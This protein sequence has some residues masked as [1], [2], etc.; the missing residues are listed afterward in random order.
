MTIDR[1]DAQPA[2]MPERL[3]AAGQVRRGWMRARE[4]P[5]FVRYGIVSGAMGVPASILQLT[6][7]VWVY[8]A[9]FGDVGTIALNVLWLVN[10]EIGLLRNFAAHCWFTWGTK[11]TWRRI[12]HAH[13]AASGALVIDLVAFNAVVYFTHIIPLAQL[14]G[15]GSGFM[16]N[17]SYN[18]LKTFSV[19]RDLA[20]LERNG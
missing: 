6:V 1:A 9:I 2:V 3:D 18:K 7:M 17:F 19:Q 8:R 4:L 16:F 11:P 12:Q 20:T 13:V 10:F 15:A 14:F 5:L